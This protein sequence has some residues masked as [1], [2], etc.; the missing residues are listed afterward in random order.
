MTWVSSLDG[1]TKGRH[2]FVPEKLLVEAERLAKRYM[3]GDEDE[4]EDENME[5]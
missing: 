5:S 1:P 2:E 4:E 3:E